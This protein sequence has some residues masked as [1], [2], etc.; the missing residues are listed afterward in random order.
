MASLHFEGFVMRALAKVSFKDDT[1]T[2]AFKT[3]APSICLTMTKAQA[4]HLAGDLTAAVDE[5]DGRS[6]Y[7]FS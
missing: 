2:L 3:N 5:L 4:R 7:C 1:V 6:T